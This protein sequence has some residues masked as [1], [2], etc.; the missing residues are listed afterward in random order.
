MAYLYLTIAIVTEVIA[1]SSLK[2]TEGLTKPA[3]TLVVVAG[4]GC[5]FYFLSLVVC[6]MDVG[7]AYA[8]WS[9]AGIVL[10]TVTA[11]IFYRQVPDL[12]A[13][14]GMAMIIA[15]VAVMNLFSQTVSR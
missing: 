8:I 11:A 10:V 1:T 13:M 14:F 6:H 2:A 12:P 9:G 4:Y 3:P 15:G 7:V 5:A